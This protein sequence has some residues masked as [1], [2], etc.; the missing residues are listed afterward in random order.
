M[1]K[2]ELIEVVAADKKAKIPSKAAA[3]RAINAVLSGISKGIRKDGE[4][5]LIGFGSFRIRNRP[6]RKVRHPETGESIRIKA[7]KTVAFRCG[8]DLKA[9]AARSRAVK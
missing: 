6:S 1:N 4:T 3:E 5:L 9:V 8:I 2:Q 7:S